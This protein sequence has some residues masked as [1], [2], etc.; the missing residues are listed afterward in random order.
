MKGTY[1]KVPNTLL[2]DICKAELSGRN[3]RVLLFIVRY[4]QGFNRNSAKLSATFI[5]NGTGIDERSVKRI[6]KNLEVLEYIKVEKT[7]KTSTNKIT[8]TSGNSATS[9]S[10]N[11]TTNTSGNS[12]TQE[13]KGKEKL[14]SY[15]ASADAE[16]KRRLKEI[17]EAEWVPDEL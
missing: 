6:V 9:A 16:R 5:A 17:M 7:S 3:L 13:R 11:F 8:L 4:T 14:S 15:S 2:N 12:A 1:T 10:G